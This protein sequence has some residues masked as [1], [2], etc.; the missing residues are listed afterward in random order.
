VL[1]AHDDS[2]RGRGG[3]SRRPK[4]TKFKLTVIVDLPSSSDF[5]RRAQLKKW[6]D[7]H[8]SLT[9]YDQT[10]SMLSFSFQLLFHLNRRRPPK[11]K[12]HRRVKGLCQNRT[13]WTLEYRIWLT[14]MTVVRHPRGRG[15]TIMSCICYVTTSINEQ[16]SCI[17][18]DLRRQQYGRR[19]PPVIVVHTIGILSQQRRSF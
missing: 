9:T 6:M 5:G 10:F 4:T 18:S 17:C 19:V 14:S 1:T 7:T 16:T 8:A 3:Q 13:Q 11:W 12:Q 2:L 15:F